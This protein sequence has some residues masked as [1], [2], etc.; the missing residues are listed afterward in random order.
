MATST[1]DRDLTI[2]KEED[3]ERF[4]AYMESEPKPLPRHENFMEDMKR[5]KDLLKRIPLR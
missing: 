2:T 3:I 4:W 5:C 1:F